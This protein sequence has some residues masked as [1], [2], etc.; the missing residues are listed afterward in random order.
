MLGEKYTSP[1]GYRYHQFLY[2][3]TLYHK[4]RRNCPILLQNRHPYLKFLLT[5]YYRMYNKFPYARPRGGKI[6]LYL[7]FFN[8]DFEQI[9][10]CQ[11]SKSIK[12][13]LAKQVPTLFLS[14]INS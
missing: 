2:V 10:G 14:L 1:N 7:Y 9:I 11:R 8:L 6:I 4:N 5:V 3:M 13:L 12:L